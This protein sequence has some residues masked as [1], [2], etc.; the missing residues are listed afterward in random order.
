MYLITFGD[1]KEPEAVIPVKSKTNAGFLAKSLRSLKQKGVLRLP[2]PIRV[3]KSDAAPAR[4]KAAKR[5][6]AKKTT[7]RKR[8]R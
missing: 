2:N 7:T 4:P 1:V 8:S 3:K 5:A 6:P